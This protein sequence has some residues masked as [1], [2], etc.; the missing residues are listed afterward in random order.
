MRTA[1]GDGVGLAGVLVRQAGARGDLAIVVSHGITNHVRK[2]FVARALRRL[3]RTGAVLAFDLRGH[4]ASGGRSTVGDLEVR[5]VAA[6]VAVARN[7][8]YERVATLGFSLGASVVIRHA[9]L[10]GGVDAV[11]AVSSPSRWWVRD[12]PPMRRVHWML[13]SPLGRAVSPLVGVRLAD[14]WGEAPPLQPL[15]V[16]DR[17]APT[18]LLLVQGTADHY[19]PPE[20]GRAL[21]RAAG[22]DAELWLEQGMRHAES[23]MTP[24]RVDRLADWITRRTGSIAASGTGDSSATSRHGR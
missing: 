11:V 10:H 18:P 3:S 4:G 21:W 19:F 13:E 6:A 23:A 22:G 7:L 12:T 15:E 2:P 16:V 24:E 9:A 20:H 8:G 1:T 14:P 17:I 5:D